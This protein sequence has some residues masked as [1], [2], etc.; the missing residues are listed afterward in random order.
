MSVMAED[1]DTVCYVY[2]IVPADVVTDE[3]ARG[4]GG[5]PV[6]TVTQGKIAA[7]AGDIPRDKPLGRPDDLIAHE[8][9]LD[10]AAAETPVLPFRFGSV[11][12][13]KEAVAD[14]LLAPYHDEFLSALTEL[15][16]R[17]EYVLHGRYVEETILREVL[18][19]HEEAARLHEQL[20]A[21]GENASQDERVALGEFLFNAV[22]AKREKD[23]HTVA[24]ALA[25]LTVAIA[26]RDPTH[27]EDAV[28]IAFLVDADH[29]QDFHAAVAEIAEEWA[30]R[31]ELRVLGPLAPYDFTVS[32][33]TPEG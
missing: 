14:E 18:S 27:E 29:E 33:S 25:P 32:R 6:V 28:N 17:Q 10:L 11:M 21:Q 4:V 8:R 26:P 12:S 2:G 3:Q 1:K 15:D 22:A 31:V 16:G 5:T 30:S 9:L 20:R 13:S 24:D 19:E 7:L 23:S